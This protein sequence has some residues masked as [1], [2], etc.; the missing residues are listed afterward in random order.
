MKDKSALVIFGDDPPRGWLQSVCQYNVV[1]ASE[2]LRT[3][4]E[5]RNL[6]W[7]DIEK[8][9]S[10]GS[11]YEATSFLEELSRLKHD[12]G[13][14][15]SKSCIYEGYELW[16]LHYDSLFLYFCLPYT[17]YKNLLTY[18]KD[19]QNVHFY[20]P[21]YKNLFAYYLQAYG[22]EMVIL[23]EP[24]LKSPTFLPF[25][26]LLQILITLLCLPILAIR[27][28][29]LMVYTGDKFE[30]SKDYDFR[31]RF[32]Y[33]ELRQRKIPFV[34]FIRGLESWEIVLKHAFMR[35]RPVIYSEAVAFVGKFC[36][37]LSGGR[38]RAKQEF[39]VRRFSPETDPEVRFKFLIASQYLFS[40]YD[41]VWA[42]RI[43]KW[44]LRVIGIKSAFIPSATE[45]NFHAV[46]GCKLNTIPTVGI[47]H[48]VASRF[49]NGYDFLPGF[50]GEKVL[51]VDKYGLWSEWWRHYY[52]ENSNA[53]RPEQLYVS[54]PMRPLLNK[55]AQPIQESVYGSIKVLFVSE[56]LAVPSEILPYLQSL[57]EA[58]GISISMTVRPYRDGF[59]EW[60]KQHN[61][62]ILE[63]I[64]DAN[65]IR[66][67]IQDAI[68]RSEVVVGAHSTS[69][70]E[71]LL[72]LK[73]PI[74]LRTQKWGDYY[75]LSEYDKKRSFFAESPKD[76][77][78]KI[79]NVRSVP[80][81]VLKDL[82]ER[83][84][85]DSY[86]NGSK[87]VVDQLEDKLL[88]GRVTK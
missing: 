54:G 10:P 67:G 22:S 36:S 86:K 40:V 64:G 26:V 80:P 57:I 8:L 12:D 15:L 29:R 21:T 24:G 85:G 87:W 19:F 66:T 11:I 1:V 59:E 2:K 17:Q 77:I 65:I 55:I 48:G 69:V 53:Y 20:R 9:V 7:I 82:R 78:E 28:S 27:K 46:L 74:Y 84:F 81:S 42:I 31:M 70:I 25:G 56:Q 58:N 18:L 34:E 45:R 51:S 30:K 75:N 76:L 60:L 6:V 43:M 68:A 37:F 35:R 47:L 4:V 23:R 83:Y 49:Y 62:E 13:S 16:W 33:E 61:P 50:D 32:I 14:R 41:D 5:A 72:S 63:K 39:C 3:E 44:I 38:Y 52:L 79:Q 71:A 73:V 88:K